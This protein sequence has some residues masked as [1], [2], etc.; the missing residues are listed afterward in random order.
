MTLLAW[1]PADKAGTLLSWTYANMESAVP[2]AKAFPRA[3]ALMLVRGT[4]SNAQDALA[5]AAGNDMVLGASRHESGT[6]AKVQVADT[7]NRK[8]A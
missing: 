6:M 4:Y 7:P 1:T 3:S 5:A 2:V 8:S